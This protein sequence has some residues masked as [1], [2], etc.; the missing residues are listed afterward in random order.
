MHH[1][2]CGQI[3]HLVDRSCLWLPGVISLPW[4][5]WCDRSRMR[6]LNKTTRVS[7][8]SGQVEMVA[9]TRGLRPESTRMWGLVVWGVHWIEGGRITPALIM[10]VEGCSQVDRPATYNKKG[11]A[12]QPVGI[13][14]VPVT[15]TDIILIP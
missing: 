6:K 3:R 11:G 1:T 15:C 2:G 5:A 4:L 10:H 13:V 8:F 9:H 12:A 14:P 7:I